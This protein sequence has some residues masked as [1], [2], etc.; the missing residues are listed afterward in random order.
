V[1]AAAT[2]TAGQRSVHVTGRFSVTE[3]S[4]EGGVSSVSSKVSADLRQQPVYGDL[5]LSGLQVGSTSI[6]S[7]EELVT[8][9]AFYLKAPAVASAVGTPWIEVRTSALAAATGV[10]FSQLTQQ[11]QQVE[12]DQYVR[13]LLVAD[14]LHRVGSATVESVATT[15]Y[16]GVVS[17]QQLYTRLP[18]MF[19]QQAR[20]RLQALGL[21]GE[22]L[23][24]WVDGQGLVR[25]VVEVSIGGSGRTLVRE[26]LSRYGES[27]PSHVP[28]SRLVT[29]ESGALSGASP[30]ATGPATTAAPPTPGS[31][32]PS[33]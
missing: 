19:D 27:V 25:R 12:P 32:T 2:T 29:D 15:H 33:A 26:N 5:H 18:T 1:Q 24:V 6:G 16:A 28:P 14:D 8:P 30:G 10:D 9:Q 22:H 11:A 3:P 23:D 31:T 17:L 7:A 21:T 4:A 13:Q 20:A